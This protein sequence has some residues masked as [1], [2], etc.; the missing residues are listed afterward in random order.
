MGNCKYEQLAHLYPAGAITPAEKQEFEAHMSSCE[1]CRAIASE[2]GEIRNMAVAL[3]P[4]QALH[5]LDERILSG[6]RARAADS[7]QSS[8]WEFLH[9]W[10]RILAPAAIAASLMLFLGIFLTSPD[11][12]TSG[13][14]GGLARASTPSEYLV[15]SRLDTSEQNYLADDSE[16]AL[17]SYYDNLTGSD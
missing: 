15:L 16:T 14:S 1:S 17:S 7:G 2:V 9:R 8:Q 4:E 3:G 12:A 5:G 6:I 11:T 13:D 10:Q